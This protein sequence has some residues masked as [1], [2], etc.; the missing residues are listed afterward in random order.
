MQHGSSLQAC[1][2]K[3]GRR[4]HVGTLGQRSSH[5]FRRTKSPAPSRPTLSVAV[6]KAAASISRPVHGLDSER[7]C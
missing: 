3:V 4:P 6:H 1:T 5:G 7:Q 2:H